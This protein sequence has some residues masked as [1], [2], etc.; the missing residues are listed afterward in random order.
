MCV[1]EIQINGQM[2]AMLKEKY[3]KNKSEKYYYICDCDV[4]HQYNIV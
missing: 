3:E 4:Y 1:L 2:V